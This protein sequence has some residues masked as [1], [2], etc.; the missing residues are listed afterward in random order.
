MK[1]SEK[2]ISIYIIEDELLICDILCDVIGSIKGCS[3]AGGTTCGVR[4]IEN[5]SR[6][7]PDIVFADI[8][9]NNENGFDLIVQIKEKFPE[10]KIIILSGYCNKTLL[11]QAVK[12]GA[13]GY[14]TKNIKI[15][16]IADAIKNVYSSHSFYIPSDVGYNLNDVITDIKLYPNQFALTRREKEI[17][18]L[19]ANEYSTK[20]IAEKLNI[21]E[22]TVRNHKS[23]MMQ[24]LDIKSDAGLV[25]YAYYMAFI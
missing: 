20:E 2:D 3:L 6:K 13:N 24:K 1:K 5:I 17:L 22:K 25:K 15:D 11:G 21:S 7:R 19:I 23:H 4:A 12:S 8:K 18:I 14:L 16:Y 9:L 10:T